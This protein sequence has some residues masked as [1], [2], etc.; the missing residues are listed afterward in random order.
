MSM[1]EFRDLQPYDGTDNLY[2]PPEALFVDGTALEELVTG[3]QTL[4]VSGRELIGYEITTA[5]RSGHDGKVFQNATRPDR[6]IVVS[7]KLSA[8]SDEDFRF[9]FGNLNYLLAKSQFQ[10]SFADEPDYYFVATLSDVDD[11]PEGRNEIAS[12]FTLYCSDPYKYGTQAETLT[13][14][15]TIRFG[16]P[17]YYPHPPEEVSVKLKEA[18]KQVSVTNGTETIVLNGNFKADD[19]IQIRVGD[20]DKIL[21]NGD[22][23]PELH[24]YLSDL[25][26][27][28]IRSNVIFS[29]TPVSSELGITVRRVRL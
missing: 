27:F 15:G 11:V 4:N 19:L 17:V 26:N 20:A 12:K 14:T 3:Y 28:M 25:E 8:D 18:A 23:H 1:Y 2:L 21:L 9:K 5:D 10:A 16:W 6:K 24:D 22:P 29:V 7:Y 13:G